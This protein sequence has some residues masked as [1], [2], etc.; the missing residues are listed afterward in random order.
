MKSS[1][2]AL[3]FDV[4]GTLFDVYSVKEKC[5]DLYGDKGEEISIVWRQKQLQYSFLRQLMGQYEPFS[6][7]TRDALDY[8]LT[9]LELPY[10][11]EK[12]ETLLEA[13]RNLE[14][15]PESAE[16]LEQMR[17]KKI[18]VFS[19]GSRDMLEPLIKNSVL[20]ELIDEIISVDDIKQYKPTPASYSYALKVLGVERHEVLFMSSNE[21]DIAGAK[22]FGF[23]TAW[24]NRDGMPLDKLGMEPDSI[25]RDLTGIL[26]WQ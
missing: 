2:Q 16:I 26:E 21:W 9:K 19:N 7:I 17:D 22:S 24:I 12:V 15:H 20:S 5:R 25:Y 23:Q 11:E 18:A 14:A 1:I 6:K 3:I 8:T 10:D 13:Y 4:Y